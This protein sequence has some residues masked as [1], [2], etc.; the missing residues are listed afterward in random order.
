[1]TGELLRP[2]AAAVLEQGAAK[3]YEDVN[4]SAAIPGGPSGA[5]KP[6]SATRRRSRRRDTARRRRVRAAATLVA[7]GPHPCSVRLEADAE[8]HPE[9]PGCLIGVAARRVAE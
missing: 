8:R 1:M 7:R 2:A 5:S 3:R 4:I 9:R 6:A